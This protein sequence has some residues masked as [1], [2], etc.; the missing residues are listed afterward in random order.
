MA[1]INDIIHLL[2]RT[3]FIA[4]PARVAELVPLTLEAAVDNILD[5]AP[6]QPVNQPVFV[7]DL[8]VNWA[9]RLQ[10]HDW[11]IDRMATAPRPFQEKMTLFWHGHFVTEWGPI[12]RT[13]YIAQNIDL[14]R[15][16]ALGKFRP[17]THAMA[18]DTQMMFYLS[19]RSNVKGTP[20]EN[21]GRELLELFTLGVGNYTEEDVLSCARAWTGHNLDGAGRYAFY[22]TRHDT[23]MKTFFGVTRN[24]DGP[25]IIDEIL[26]NNKPKQLVSAQ[27]IARKLWEFL[28]YQNPA[29]GIVDALAAEFVATDLDIRRLCRA[30]LLRPEFYSTEARRGLVRS[31]VEYSVAIRAHSGVSARNLL[32]FD[33][34]LQM[35]QRLL[36]P[37]NVAGWKQNAYYLSTSALSARANVAKRAASQIRAGG[38]FDWLKT[39]GAETAVDTVA[40]HFGLSLAPTT[41]AALVNGFNS[42][43][44]AVGGSTATAVTNLFAAMLLTGEMNAPA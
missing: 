25:E 8:S 33:W 4:R 7:H 3:E 6:N 9:Q 31:P 11:W 17:F 1:D 28:A 27:F 37:P 38:N 12:E 20:N 34:A 18:K 36:D 5:T 30:I 13:D 24:W 39:A 43:A 41:R 19:N 21:F 35:G 23:G 15:T 26:L 2:R 44:R 16:N 22:P 40:N 14:Y 42:E 10:F 29:Q 32:I